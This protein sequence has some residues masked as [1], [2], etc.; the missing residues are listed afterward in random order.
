[1]NSYAVSPFQITLHYMLVCGMSDYMT[2]K[3]TS[4]SMTTNQSPPHARFAFLCLLACAYFRV[5]IQYEILCP[6]KRLPTDMVTCHYRVTHLECGYRSMR[7]TN[8]VIYGDRDS[9]R[10]HAALLSYHFCHRSSCYPFY[11]KRN[12]TTKKTSP[13]A[14][15]RKLVQWRNSISSLSD[16]AWSIETS[17]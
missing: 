13:H 16:F 7:T 8:F 5:R 1:M 3:C 12:V 10:S 9:S 15:V 17:I 2:S 6:K 4:P 14:R 11:S